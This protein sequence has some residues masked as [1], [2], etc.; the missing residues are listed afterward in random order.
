[1]FR[2]IEQNNVQIDKKYDSLKAD[3]K[4][5]EK[6]IDA[7]VK[8]MESE[9]FKAVQRAKKILKQE[10]QQEKFDSTDVGSSALGGSIEPKAI[11][12]LREIIKTKA[13]NDDLQRLF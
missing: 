8:N 5:F 3:H 9:I 1:M 10:Q 7:I 4:T 11:E 2:E 13:N 6:K 12:E